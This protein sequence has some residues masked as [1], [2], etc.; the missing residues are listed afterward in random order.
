MLY[1]DTK[2]VVIISAFVTG[3]SMGGIVRNFIVGKMSLDNPI[4]VKSAVVTFVLIMGFCILYI[5]CTI[6]A[7]RIMK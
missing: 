3:V 5:Y 4:D 6:T 1:F 2:I 7:K